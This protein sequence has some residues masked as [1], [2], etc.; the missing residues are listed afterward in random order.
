M[1]LDDSM[2][3]HRR[4]AA[5]SPDGL[6]AVVPAGLYQKSAASAPFYVSHVL[7]RRNP[8]KSFALLPSGRKPSIAVRFCPVLYKLS[9]NADQQAVGAGV[10][11]PEK[12]FPTPQKV[13]QEQEAQTGFNM[14]YKMIFAV[15]TSNSILLYDTE[16]MTT[17]FMYVTGIHFDSLTDIAW[18]KDGQLLLATSKDGYCSMV[19]FAAGE[20]GVPLEPDAL[21]PVVAKN[22]MPGRSI[23]PSIK[24][25]EDEA[26]VVAD[27]QSEE[28]A[29]QKLAEMVAA[30][31][32][33]PEPEVI[34]FLEGDRVSARWKGGNWFGG[35]VKKVNE[36]EPVAEEPKEANESE[37]VGAAVEMVVEPQVAAAVEMVEPQVAAAV[38]MVVEPQVSVKTYAVLYDDGDFDAAVPQDHMKPWEE[39]RARKR[40]IVPQ[41]VKAVEDL[42][43]SQA[44]APDAAGPDTSADAKAAGTSANDAVQIDSE[45]SAHE[46]QS[47]K[48]DPAAEATA[49]TAAKAQNSLPQDGM[50]VSS[51][52]KEP[53]QPAVEAAPKKRRIIPTT[54][55][56]AP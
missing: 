49:E 22:L 15:A 42:K 50:P 4:R 14:P 5:W 27:V 6:F 34:E 56:P 40:R 38:E 11:T 23:D 31:A 39:K 52:P 20:L 45:S 16:Q 1:F 24:D 3:A 13:A 10:P 28:T 17:P 44:A 51:E 25:P 12:L 35:T 37:E 29:A 36:P 32:A 48:K 21:P 47:Q 43:A 18:S 2:A 54:V 7:A 26:P 33:L 53:Q 46:S 55:T 19:E 30:P 41:V 8:T 9:R